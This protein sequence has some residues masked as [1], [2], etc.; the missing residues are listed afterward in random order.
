MTYGDNEQ[1]VRQ[2]IYDILIASGVKQSQARAIADSPNVRQLSNEDIAM[3]A[4]MT[5]DPTGK[6]VLTEGTQGGTAMSAIDDSINYMVSNPYNQFN[7]G[8]TGTELTPEDYNTRLAQYEKDVNAYN[9]PFKYRGNDWVKT[10]GLV[11]EFRS[12]FGDDPEQKRL[13]DE[14]KYL[15]SVKIEFDKS[16]LVPEATARQQA[17]DTGLPPAPTQFDATTGQRNPTATKQEY[18]SR[19]YNY[20][21]EAN[22]YAQQTR[23]GKEIPPEAQKWLNDEYNYLQNVKLAINTPLGSSDRGFVGANGLTYLSK[24]QEEWGIR[25]QEEAALAQASVEEDN[26]RLAGYRQDIANAQGRL[27]P[28]ANTSA[29]EIFNRN[30]PGNLNQTTADY[31][32]NR[33]S[34]IYGEFLGTEK[35]ITPGNEELQTVERELG[36]NKRWEDFLKQYNFLQKYKGAAPVNRGEYTGRFTPKVRSLNY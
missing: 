25:A 30:L 29:S 20:N 10:K 24:D 16:G 13:Q 27:Q 31:F 28:Y 22:Y 21:D 17:A 9:A 2:E 5:T 7:K 1:A 14:Y 18:E 36:R 26:A 4:S 32:R 19:V 35:P 23:N 12:L 8:R 6:F 11:S 15:Q 33:Y 34:D 3:L